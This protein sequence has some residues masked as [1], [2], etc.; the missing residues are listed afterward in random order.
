MPDNFEMFTDKTIMAEE[1]A[2]LM[3]PVGWGFKNHYDLEK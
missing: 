3:D 1:L 2:E